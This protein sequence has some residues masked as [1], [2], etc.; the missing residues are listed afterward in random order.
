MGTRPRIYVEN[1]KTPRI[2]CGALASVRCDNAAYFFLALATNIAACV[3]VQLGDSA[4]AKT[5]SAPAIEDHIT[6]IRFAKTYADYLP[7]C[8]YCHCDQ[9]A[10]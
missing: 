6:I 9:Q 5:V 3:A 10:S 7:S 8:L 1:E 2:A 4:L